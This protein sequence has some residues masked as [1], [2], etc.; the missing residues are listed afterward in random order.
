[1]ALNFNTDAEGGDVG[2]LIGEAVIATEPP[3]AR[4]VSEYEQKYAAGIKG[5]GMTF[6]ALQKAYPVV[7][8]VTP[9]ALRG[10]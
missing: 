6:A 3:A 9:H 10:A 4:R 8:M 1:V 5:L 7:I 2:V